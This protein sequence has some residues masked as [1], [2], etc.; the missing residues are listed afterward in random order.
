MSW[1]VPWCRAGLALR[2]SFERL[3]T[4]DHVSLTS[5]SRV[6]STLRFG[7]PPRVR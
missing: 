5:A 2:F 1:A 3:G 6:A 7:E 4:S